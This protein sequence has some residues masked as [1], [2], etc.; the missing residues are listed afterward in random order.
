MLRRHLLISGTGLLLGPAARLLAACGEEA[1]AAD[2]LYSRVL[3]AYRG[4]LPVDQIEALAEEDPGPALYLGPKTPGEWG[5]ARLFASL[6]DGAHEE[7][8][9]R[10]YLKWS[11]HA[12]PQT[13]RGWLQERIRQ[14]ERRGEG[15]FPLEGK[16][17]SLTGFARVELEGLSG[18]QYAWWIAH[19]QAKRAQWLTLVRVFRILTQEYSEANHQR[20]EEIAGLPET[21]PIPRGAWQKVKDPPVPRPSEA[22]KPPTLMDE[23]YYR[24][25]VRA[26]RGSLN[27]EERELL[28]ASDPLIEKRLKMTDP[29][30]RALNQLFGRLKEEEHLTLLTTGKLL[31]RPHELSRERRQQMEVIVARLNAQSREGGLGELYDLVPYG[32]TIA[33]FSILFI[34]EVEKPVLSWWIRSPLSPTPAW[35]TL[36]NGEAVKAPQYYRTHLE[37]L[38]P[39]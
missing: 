25:V 23:T 28:A 13:Q 36:I 16:A 12:L 18:P 19:P 9:R 1:P 33:G 29:A 22:E 6:P 5:V 11:A 39:D 10:G 30:D 4:S 27:R 35:I 17:A 26:Y 8:R 32:R 34:P 2:A 20:L 24:R 31:L 7:L 15:P 3:A 14:L 38:R 37:Q 21:T